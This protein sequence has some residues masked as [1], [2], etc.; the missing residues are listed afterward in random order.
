MIVIWSSAGCGPCYAL[1]AALT[2]A[3]VQYDE[4]DAASADAD[5]LARWR[6]LGWRTPVVQYAGGEF[7]G[8]DPAKVRTVIDTAHVMR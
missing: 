4:R 1:K 3:G 2:R 7:S 6:A 8:F 5:T